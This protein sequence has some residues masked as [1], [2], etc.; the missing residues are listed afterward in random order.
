[1]TRR[2]RQREVRGR[3]LVGER[4]DVEV[5]PVA[6]GGHC[7]AR[8]EGRVIFVRHTLPG[9]RVRVEVTDGDEESRFLRADAVEVLEASPD[10]VPPPCPWSGPGRCGGCDFQHV[11]LPA[12]RDLKAAVVR[13]QLQRLAGLEVPETVEPVAGDRDGLGWRTRL[14]FAVDRDGTAGL[15]KHHSHEIVPVDVCPIGHPELPEVGTRRWPRAGAVEA[16]VSSA[17][18]QLRIVEERGRPSYDGPRVL[19]EHA[20][21][22]DWQVSGSGFWQVHPGAADALVAAVVGALEPQP[23]EHALDLYSGVGLFSSAL[24]ARVGDAGRVVAVEGDRTAVEDARRNLADL[25]QVEHLV[26]RVDRALAGG[27][28]GG[29][30]DLVVLDPPRTGAKRKVVGAVCDLEPRAVAYVACDPAALARDV[31]IFAERGYRLSRLRAF[32]IFP[33]THHV[34]CVALLERA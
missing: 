26:D 2:T 14:Q 4:Y 16:I 5:G 11:A 9:E 13:E 12:Q 20:A 33:M 29:G 8:H 22:R 25:P 31:A 30:I 3:S 28:V 7:V 18:E 34:E 15:R 23:G 10:R 1:M 6:H 32:D 27:A 19:H 24:A 17:G 21:G